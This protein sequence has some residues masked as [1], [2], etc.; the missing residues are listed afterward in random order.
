M[1]QTVKKSAHKKKTLPSLKRQK[2]VGDDTKGGR[3]DRPFKLL[4]D[5]LWAGAEWLEAHSGSTVAQQSS[6][7]LSACLLFQPV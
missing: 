7:F 5:L 6:I 1:P 4:G 2:S 3:T